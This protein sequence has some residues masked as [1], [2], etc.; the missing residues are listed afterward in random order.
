MVE[1]NAGAA[2]AGRDRGSHGH[3]KAGDPDRSPI[4]LRG[5]ITGAR[6]RGGD[7]QKRDHRPYIPDKRSIST[8]EIFWALTRSKAPRQ[9]SRLTTTFYRWAEGWRKN[10]IQ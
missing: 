3:L 8:I 10:K 2:Y 6:D 1:S 9:H 4:I 7:Q 5:T